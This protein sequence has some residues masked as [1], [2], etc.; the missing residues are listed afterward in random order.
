MQL[1]IRTVFFNLFDIH[2]PLRAHAA[3]GCFTIIIV[4]INHAL[5]TEARHSSYNNKRYTD[6]SYIDSSYKVIAAKILVLYLFL[7]IFRFERFLK[8]HLSDAR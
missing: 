7:I 6:I 2:S 4:N 3:A 5:L 8:S 1:G